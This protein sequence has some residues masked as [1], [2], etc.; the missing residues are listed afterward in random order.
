[1]FSDLSSQ[2]LPAL[3]PLGWSGVA[4][5]FLDLTG[6]SSAGIRVAAARPAAKLASP[7]SAS[8]VNRF[9]IPAGSTLMLTQYDA[10]T[11]RSRVAG[12]APPP[13]DATHIEAH[14]PAGGTY[15]VFVPAPPPFDPPASSDGS[16]LTGTAPPATNP[17]QSANVTTNP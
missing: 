1:A 13:P 2:G 14:L 12:P 17:I 10:A 11:A 3:P 16:P 9:G 4:G 15:V 5:A 6:S 8:W 7:A